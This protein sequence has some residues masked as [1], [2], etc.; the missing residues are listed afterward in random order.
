MSSSYGTHIHLTIFGESHGMAIGAVLDGLPS[1]EPVDMQALLAFMDRR[2]PGK[3]LFSTPRKETDIPQILSGV[4]EGKTTGTPLAILIPNEDTHSADYGEIAFVPRPAH[5]DYTGFLRYSGAQDPRGGGHFSGRLTAP[6]VAAG[7]IAKQIL[8]RKGIQIGAHIA[9]IGT[10]RD[11]CFSTVHLGAQELLS[12]SQ[13]DFPVLD[14]ACGKAMRELI[15]ECRT[16][17]DSVGGT[18][19]CAIVGF[20]AGVGSPLFEG[21]E[22]KLASVL[23]GIPAVKG[24]EFGAGFSASSSFGSQMNDPFVMEDGMV[25]TSSNHHGGI[26]GGISSGMPILFRVAFKPTPSISRPQQTV[27][28]TTMTDTSIT[29]HGRH[30]PCVVPRA[31]PCVEAAAAIALLDAL[32]G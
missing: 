11:A 19:E 17:Q 16:Q 23:F 6:L 32:I 29:I 7:G 4:Y 22:N 1:G 13:K 31:V 21:L 15:E 2:K 8:S 12:S 28:L 20:P 3:N 27:N 30:D 10:V 14:D 9:S 26:L 25:R 18:V 24:L 5:A